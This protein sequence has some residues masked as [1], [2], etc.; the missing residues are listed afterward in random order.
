MFD[1]TKDSDLKEIG[2][3]IHDFLNKYGFNDGNYILEEEEEI[4]EVLCHKIADALDVI[5]NKWKPC[6]LRTG[7][8]PFYILFEDIETGELISY[9]DMEERDRRKIDLKIHELFF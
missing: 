3:Y 5:V 9:F 8:N 4:V 7:H 2:F 1:L 6:I